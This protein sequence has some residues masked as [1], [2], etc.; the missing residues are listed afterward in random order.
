MNC[1]KCKYFEED[2]RDTNGINIGYCHKFNLNVNQAIIFD[3][4]SFA[5][6]VKEVNNEHK[7]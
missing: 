3:Y 4:C 6:D 7:T 5:E 1:F 2:Y